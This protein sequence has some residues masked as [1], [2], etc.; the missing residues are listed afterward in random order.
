MPEWPPEALTG[1]EV[2]VPRAVSVFAEGS[3]TLWL[4]SDDLEWMIRFLVIQQQLKGV[5]AVA[6]EDEGPDAAERMDFEMTPEKCP[7]PKKDNGHIYDKC[8]SE[9]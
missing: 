7:Q 3:G 8:D 5:P 2:Q 6:E 4:H 9:P 1:S